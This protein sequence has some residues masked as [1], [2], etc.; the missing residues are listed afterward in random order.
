LPHNNAKGKKPIQYR[1]RRCDPRP[2]AGQDVVGKKVVFVAGQCPSIL[3]A[4][5]NTM[6]VLQMTPASTNPA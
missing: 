1:G 2:A 4:T 5:V 6:H 3:P